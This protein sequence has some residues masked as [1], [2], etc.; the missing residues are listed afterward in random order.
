MWNVK[1]SWPDVQSGV[2]GCLWISMILSWLIV[3]LLFLLRSPEILWELLNAWRLWLQFPSQSLQE[4]HGSALPS[5][6]SCDILGDW[7][8]SHV[9][10]PYFQLLRS[11]TII[12][13]SIR[14]I[15]QLWC[16]TPPAQLK[17]LRGHIAVPVLRVIWSWQEKLDGRFGLTRLQVLDSR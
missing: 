1:W 10:W 14:D 6:M 5:V 9:I 8:C 2:Q 12:F 4:D 16:F 17:T 11:K 3:W 15:D 7:L 13:P